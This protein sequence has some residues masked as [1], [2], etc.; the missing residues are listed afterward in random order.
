MNKKLNVIE[1]K[2]EFCVEIKTKFAPLE[3]LDSEVDIN[4]AW[5]TVR[6]ISK[7]QSRLF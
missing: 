4:R 6:K 3:N 1:D 7:F 5:E 2:E